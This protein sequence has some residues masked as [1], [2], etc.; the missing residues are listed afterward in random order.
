MSG[1]QAAHER[2]SRGLV[3]AAP[4]SKRVNERAPSRRRRPSRGGGAS[5]HWAS[6]NERAVTMASIGKVASEQKAAA[7]ERVFTPS[8]IASLHSAFADRRL[9][10][11][12]M[13]QK[14]AKNASPRSPPSTLVARVFSKAPLLNAPFKSVLYSGIFCSITTRTAS[15][16]ANRY[17]HFASAIRGKNQYL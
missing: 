6:S 9:L 7:F 5:Y 11:A 4:K 8:P 12:L 10:A 3:V 13:V 15:S 1:A 14:R 2:R 16:L 17:C